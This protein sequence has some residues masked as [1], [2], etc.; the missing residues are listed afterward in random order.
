MQ[1]TIVNG[2]HDDNKGDSAIVLGT[3]QVLK[4]RFPG[5]QYTLV[6]AFSKQDKMFGQAHRHL[7]KRVPDLVICPSPIPF[8][9]IRSTPKAFK[10]LDA[11]RYLLR[12]LTSGLKL[13]AG[14]N[15]PTNSGFICIRSSD[16]IISK[17]GHFLHGRRAH[18]VDWAYL[19]EQAY[20]LLLARKY[21]RPYIILGQSLGPF[22]GSLNKGIARYVLEGALHIF[23]REPLSYLE[24]SNLGIPK[25]KLSIIP[26]LAF[27]ISPS[28]S[29][30]VQQIITNLGLQ[31]VRFGVFTVRQWGNTRQNERFIKEMVLLIRDLL[32]K[33]IIERAV[34]VVHTSGP[35]PH[36]D[37]AIPSKMLLNLIQDNR[38][39]LI[40]ADLSPEELAAL[41]GKAHVLIGTRFHSII[42]AVLSGT[43]VYAISYFGPKALG[44]MQ[45]LDMERFC[46]DVSVFTANKVSA[47]VELM[48]SKRDEVVSKLKVKVEV[49]RSQIDYELDRLQD[50]VSSL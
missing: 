15:T 2:W 35:T 44:I 37:D 31:N 45:M 12:T 30:R 23:V 41:Y 5:A 10:Y 11:I 46:S 26:D 49:L 33:T 4:R 27:A 50:L 40:N 34:I 3:L 21:H 25:R 43:P 36:E 19:L 24:A 42:L 38:A 28:L 6:S 20:P 47:D 14:I 18:P 16:L 29:D 48:L 7:L 9:F 17:G 39:H 1:I 8:A 13:A 32:S 22:V